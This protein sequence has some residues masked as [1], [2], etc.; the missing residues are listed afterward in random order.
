MSEM[1]QRL[2]FVRLCEAGGVSMTELCR[3]FGISRQTGHLL[4]RRYRAE[5]V[6]GL[7]PRSRRPRTSPCRTSAPVEA[8]VLAVRRE[9]P[10]WGGRKI[11][12]RL[13]DL[14]CVDVPS[15]STATEVLRR[16]GVLDPAE[17]ARHA[18][19]QRFERE[20]PNELWQMDFKGHVALDAGR[21]HPLTVLD[22][23]S[24]YALG[25][26]A[27]CDETASTVRDRLTAVFRRYGLPQAMLADNG[28]PWGGKGLGEYTAFEVWLMRLGVK[29][30]HG[31][32]YHPQ[33][34]GKDER[35]HRTLNAEVLQAR[36]FAD[37]AQCQ[38][39]FDAWRRVYNEQRP[40]EALGLDVPA[41]RYT[42][43]PAC[44]PEDLPRPDYDAA[45][46]VR[47]VRHDG[48]VSFKGRKAKL[49]E[50]FA[51]L[52]VAFRPTA[53]DGV[54][55]AYFMRFRVASIDVRSDET[56]SQT[57]RDVS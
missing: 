3:R 10:A 6:A 11:A 29:L 24:R 28:S 53:Q 33:T 37:L 26:A 44:F 8:A 32:P 16:H 41:S 7:V 20:R 50:A 35:F 48:Y 42:A 17:A 25:L 36:R 49:S 30:M 23:R 27:C 21:C 45:D 34:Q 52:D 22:D 13:A 55:N 56:H 2:E 18:P 5:G 12:R 15:A 43:S 39:A 1:D 38:A 19:W 51:R 9:H 40:H 47:R 14:G 4:L 54:W 57:V 31:R 46:L